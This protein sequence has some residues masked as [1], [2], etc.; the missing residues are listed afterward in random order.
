[1][2]ARA[3]FE[4]ICKR[5]TAMADDPPFR[6]VDTS[7]RDAEAYLQR[8]KTFVGYSEQEVARTEERLGVVFPTLFRTYLLVMGRPPESR[9]SMNSEPMLSS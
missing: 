2:E 8:M 5:L 3:I 9:T 7:E 6:F 4:G 1:M